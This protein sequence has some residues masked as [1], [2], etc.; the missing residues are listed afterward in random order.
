MG[1]GLEGPWRRVALSHVVLSL[2]GG[3]DHLQ[4]ALGEDAHHH[5]W[6]PEVLQARGGTRGDM[7]LQEPGP[8][9]MSPGAGKGFLVAQNS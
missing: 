7:T 3:G 9:C 1:C 6:H 4:G 5:P 2:W 8:S